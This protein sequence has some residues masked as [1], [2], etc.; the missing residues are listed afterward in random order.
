[1][2]EYIRDVVDRAVQDLH[3]KERYI[4]DRK[5]PGQPPVFPGYP[6]VSHYL[7]LTDSKNMSFSYDTKI[8]PSR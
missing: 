4:K 3:I 6:Q 5:K 7:S 8:L 1:M 2:L